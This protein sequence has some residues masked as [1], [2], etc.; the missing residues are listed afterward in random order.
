[1]APEPTVDDNDTRIDDLVLANRILVREGVLDAFGHVSVRDA[2]RQDR[3]FIARSMAPEW[4]TREDI[5]VCDLD[6]QVHD[7]A[8]RRTY[9]E[10][11]IHSEIYRARPD[12]QAVVHSHS[13]AVIPFG[14]TGARL[15]PVCHLGGFLGSGAPVF[16]IRHSVGEASDLLVRNQ[17][18]GRALAATLG[19]GAVALLRG[20]GAVA[21]GTSL[22]QAVFRA[23]YAEV[24]A[25]LQ[26]QSMALGPT[27]FL[28]EA[29]AFAAAEVND[30]QL[31]R[32]W[33]AWK[34]K[35]LDERATRA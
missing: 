26:S 14:V 29:E 25:R 21:V 8:G 31:D 3:F 11:F 6:A 15:R 13:P 10:R 20:H 18:L 9:L 5:L 19:D 24:N 17:G 2:T 7:A 22:H 30:G 4:V 34:R 16:E 33:D 23:V 12:V 27:T 32:A 35:V 1:M 28:S